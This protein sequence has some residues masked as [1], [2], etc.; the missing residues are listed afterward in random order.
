MQSGLAA[1]FTGVEYLL[2]EG[3]AAM[4]NILICD[5]ERDIVNALKIYLNDANY[6]L[7][8]AFDGREA[9][10]IVEEQQ[11]HLLLRVVQLDAPAAQHLLTHIP[12][13]KLHV[14]AKL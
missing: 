6:A 9:L 10:K 12:G 8:E 5:D 1:S 13:A 3:H 7:F 4:Y 14:P 2:R 11:Q